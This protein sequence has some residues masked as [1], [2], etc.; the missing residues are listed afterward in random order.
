MTYLVIPVYEKSID[1]PDDLLEATRSRG[2]FLVLM[3]DTS[4]HF[5]IKVRVGNSLYSGEEFC[6]APPPLFSLYHR[7][8]ELITLRT[9]NSH[10]PLTILYMQPY[11]AV[12]S[13]RGEYSKSN[14]LKEIYATRT[15]LLVKNGGFDKLL[16][17]KVVA[18]AGKANIHYSMIRKG[19]H[20]YHT[21]R[22]S[23][24]IEEYGVVTPNGAPY[25]PRINEII[26]R[27]VE[28]GLVEHWIKDEFW[29]AQTKHKRQKEDDEGLK[30]M[31]MDHL[32]SAF[33]LLLVGWGL[34][35]LALVAELVTS[36]RSRARRVE[37]RPYD[38]AGVRQG[39]SVHP[40]SLGNANPSTHPNTSEN[41][42][43]LGKSRT[44]RKIRDPRKTRTPRL[45]RIPQQ[46]QTNRLTRIPR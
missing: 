36:R 41:P 45:I 22:E 28:A 9:K 2:Y 31:G 5:S 30:A 7:L 15:K 43:H 11:Q 18:M 26:T 23:H 40:I 13:Y 14:V 35:F 24:A 12:L 39:S 19:L 33:L 32:V 3:N 27:L 1:N 20:L 25:L 10:A 42:E 44:P 29:K 4:W 46:N 8:V 21:S 16:T 38:E 6:S 37:V 34:S 17:E